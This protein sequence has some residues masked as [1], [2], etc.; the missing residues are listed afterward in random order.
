VGKLKNVSCPGCG[1]DMEMG[2]IFSSREIAW[3]KDGKSRI[4]PGLYESE[5]LIGGSWGVKVKKKVAYR[6]EDCNI[7][8]FEYEQS[9]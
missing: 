5:T 9:L 3:T 7:V 6:C 1:R 4:A 2:H 8:L